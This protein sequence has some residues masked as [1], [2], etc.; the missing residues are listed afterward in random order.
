MVLAVAALLGFAGLRPA[1]AVPRTVPLTVET[2]GGAYVFHVEI[3]ADE[4][5]RTQGLM[6][7]RALAPD[8]GM[9]FVFDA[10]APVSFWMKNTY[11]PLDMVFIRADGVVHRVEANAEPLSERPIDSGAPVRYVLEIA[12]GRAAAIGLKRGDKVLIPPLK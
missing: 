2:A 1:L 12:G 7:R 8:A 5:A 11:I 10:T 6:Y 9:L 4:A 3:A